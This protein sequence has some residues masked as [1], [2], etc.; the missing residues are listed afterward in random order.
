MIHDKGQAIA[1][2]VN[3]SA[4]RISPEPQ[5]NDMFVFTM[6]DGY[7]SIASKQMG[8]LSLHTNITHEYR[9]GM[10]LPRGASL[11]NDAN[12]VE[13]Q[14]AIEFLAQRLYDVT[15]MAVPTITNA[16]GALDMGGARAFHGQRF[17][18]SGGSPEEAILS[19]NFK[20]IEVLTLDPAYPERI[21]VALFPH[22]HFE[23]LQL[24]HYPIITAQEAWEML[25]EGYFVSNFADSLWPGRERALNAS[26]ELVYHMATFNSEV[27]AIMPFYRFLVEIE[28][29]LW[30]RDN[31]GD[32]AG[33]FRAFARYYVPA[34]HR[35][36]LEPMTR[37]RLSEPLVAPVGPRA[38]PPDIFAIAHG[39]S[40]TWWGPMRVERHD[41]ARL[42]NEV[43][44]EIG[45]LA[46]NEAYQFR[47]ACGHYAMIKGNRI[48]TTREELHNYF[49]GYDHVLNGDVWISRRRYPGYDLPETLGDF[50]LQEISVFDQKESVMFI[51][52]R[53]MTSFGPGFIIYN[54]GEPAPVGEIFARRPV[55]FSIFAMYENSEGVQ[56][57]L[58]ITQPV[59]GLHFLDPSEDPHTTLDMGEYGVIHFQGYPGRYFRALH[60]A[61]DMQDEMWLSATLE[62]WFVNGGTIDGRRLTWDLTYGSWMH[63]RPQGFNGT[64][65]FTP[66]RQADLEELVRIFDPAAL[67]AEYGWRLMSLQ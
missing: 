58:G 10:N 64:H 22:E 13:V 57:G 53:P 43:I 20:W 6:L 8:T 42:W 9:E 1:A 15:P 39:M 31:L 37:R 46:V 62:L 17:F 40:D 5:V 33:D 60:E 45:E 52:D 26:V 3:I 11:S 12:D 32:I 2:T 30:H 63:E 51:F 38:L 18:D 14:L 34:V 61:I 56:V 49:P 54:E 29:P 24:G 19:F 23:S 59:M 65:W 4:D 41:V 21:E 44:S 67:F 7:S 25:L 66:V 48:F 28:M 16:Q 55:V 36:Y 50:S 27:E 47:T 35:D